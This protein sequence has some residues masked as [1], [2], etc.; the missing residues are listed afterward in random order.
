MPLK[1]LAHLMAEEDINPEMEIEPSMKEPEKKVQSISETLSK[2]DDNAD[3]KVDHFEISTHD[4][5]GRSGGIGGFLDRI[6]DDDPELRGQ[7][8]WV[9]FSLSLI[10]VAALNAYAMLRAPD[11]ITIDKILEHKNEVV[12]VEGILTSWV[13][14]PYGSGDDRIDMII[15]DETGVIELRW[16]R[17]GDIPPLGTYVRAI[18]D[19]IEYDGRLWLQAMG[20]GALSWSKS[21]VPEVFP[22]TVSEVAA[23]PANY[24]LTAITLTGYLSKSIEPEASF[25]S[26]YLGDHPNYGNSDHQM[27]MV[28][29]SAPGKWLEAGQKV[30]VTGILSYEQRELRWTLHIEGPEI[31]TINTYTPPIAKLDWSTADTWSYSSNNIVEITGVLGEGWILSGESYQICIIPKDDPSANLGQSITFQGRLLWSPSHNNWCIDEAADGT[32]SA[33]IVAVGDAVDLLGMI[34]ADPSGVLANSSRTWIVKAYSKYSVEPFDTDITFVDS[35]AYSQDWTTLY[36]SFDGTNTWIEA[37]QEM[38]INVSVGWD[39]ANTRMSVMV[40]SFELSG[41][42]PT[43]GNI[44]WDDGAT[45]WSY[46]RNKL[47]TIS[48]QVVD[49]GG[50]YYLQRE[51]GTQKVRLDPVIQAIGLN[52]DY[53]DYTLTWEGRLLQEDDNSNMAQAFVLANADAIDENS[54]GIPDELE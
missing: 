39:D 22:T 13:E 4:G 43:A 41:E 42:T 40:N 10:L 46:S 27:R 14:D 21:N 25:S 2:Y 15:E 38:V 19:V 12:A 44:F 48:G 18:G 37:G 52:S 33:G 24:S 17:F 47:V 50:Q 35:P 3:G 1:H 45:Q 7:R 11:M 29:H 6:L 31:R 53:S 23:N 28:I 51:G 20:A 32:S 49:E 8:L 26:L 30:E 54:N 5:A 34:S 16:Y 9:M 36:G